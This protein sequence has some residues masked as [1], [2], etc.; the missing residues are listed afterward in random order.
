MEALPVF[1]PKQPTFDCALMLPPNAAEGWVIVMLRMAVQPFASVMV[2]V[3]VPA[4][5]PVALDDVC[6]GVV[7]QLYVYG[8]V[9]PVALIE[10]LPV[11]AP[12]QPTLACALTLLVSAAAGC[13]MMTF[14][15]T[16]HP[17]ASVMVQVHV[18][19]VKFVAVAPVCAGAVFQLYVYGAVP[20]AAKIVAP[21]VFAPKHPTFV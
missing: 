17:F 5:R 20:P 2:Q 14:R 21:P 9:P 19:A 8:P 4:P 12:K 7:F 3:H 18:P 1:A 11:L 6:T 16:L 10:A 15:V 13:M